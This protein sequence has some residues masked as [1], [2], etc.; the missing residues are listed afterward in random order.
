LY[1]FDQLTPEGSNATGLPRKLTTSSR[2]GFL[3]VLSQS[4]ENPGLLLR[5]DLPFE[6]DLS[7]SLVVGELQASRSP[8]RQDKTTMKRES[9]FILIFMDYRMILTKYFNNDLVGMKRSF[10][11]IYLNAMSKILTAS[12]EK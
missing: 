9:G 8:C 10:H 12:G 6:A 4:K 7:T 11:P 2:Q 3:T 5:A 1:R